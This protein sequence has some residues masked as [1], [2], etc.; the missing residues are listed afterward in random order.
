[1]IVADRKPLA[2]IE[3]MLAPYAK[4][5]VVGCSSCVGVCHAGAARDVAQLVRSLRMAG[6]ESETGWKLA[7]ETVNRQCEPEFVQPLADRVDEAEVVLS[8]GCG[9]GV[10]T[11]ADLFGE[12]PIL[13][14]LNTTFMGASRG[15]GLFLEWCVGCGDCILDKTAAI[16]PVSRCA[17]NLLNGPCGGSQRGKCEISNDI[18]CVWHEIYERLEALNKSAA[19][20]EIFPPKDWSSGSDGKPRRRLVELVQTEEAE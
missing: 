18:P 10:Q 12:K 19:L 13:P 8:L 16:C 3:D 14:A 11:M 2:E 5:L 7:E 20:E 15:E 9:L 1:M 6:K 17:K 4:V